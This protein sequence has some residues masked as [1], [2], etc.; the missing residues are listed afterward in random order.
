MV[1]PKE[2]SIFHIFAQVVVALEDRVEF[3]EFGDGVA[4]VPMVAP[5]GSGWLTKSMC[6]VRER[7]TGNAFVFVEVPSDTGMSG[8]S[9][10]REMGVRISKAIGD[11]NE[12]AVI[13]AL[14]A[15]GLYGG[16]LNAIAS[17][18]GRG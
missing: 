13:A 11:P 16:G 15:H 5:D 10:A 1:I 17:A 9:F 18:S 14:C 7:H 3:Y 8:W 6:L 12:K 4:A 2:K